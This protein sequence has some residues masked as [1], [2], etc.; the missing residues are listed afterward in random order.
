MSQQ[1]TR[2]PSE[3]REKQGIAPGPHLARVVGHLDPSYMGTLKVRILRNRGNTPGEDSKTYNVKPAFPFFGYTGYEYM[4]VNDAG[5]STLDAYNDTQKSYGMWFVPPDIGV[6]VLIM[7]V[8]GDPAQGFWVGCVPSNFA[9]HMVPAIGA[10]PQVDMDSRDKERFDTNKPLPVAEINRRRNTIAEPQPQI[11]PAQIK[12]PLHPIAE[13]FLEQGLVEDEIRGSTTTT[14][15]RN[16]PSSVYGIS[17][18]GPRDKRP[19]AKKGIIGSADSPA[20]SFISRLGGTQFVMD[21]G[22]ER[23][24]RKAPAGELPFE[25]AYADL[26]AGEKGD[27]AI[28]FNEYFRVRTRTG[29]QILMHNSEDL[30]YIG[31]SRGT[32]WIELTSNGKIDI[33]AQDS[34]SIHTENDLNVRA[35][36]DINMEA[37]RNVNIKAT[38]EYQDKENLHEEKSPFDASGHESGRVYIESVQNMDL[39]IGRNGKIHVKN[40]DQVEGNLDI[41]VMGNMRVSVKDLNEDPPSFTSVSPTRNEATQGSPDEDSQGLHIYSHKNTKIY[42]KENF[43]SITEGNCKVKIEGTSDIIANGDAKLFVDSNLDITISKDAKISSGGSLHINTTSSNNFTA[44]GDTNI[45]SGGQHIEEAAK[46]NMNGPP[47]K[48]ADL[49]SLAKEAGKADIADLVR[50]LPTYD[51]IKI[52]NY[53]DWT[54]IRHRDGAVNS[55]MKRI[56]MHEPWPNHE[57]LKP[58]TSTPDD[59]DREKDD[60]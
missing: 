16:L 34:I 36:R 19:G 12:K 20:T 11:D 51:N 60:G 56:P 6:V 18:P 2:T 15:R 47:A 50:L 43:D 17:T 32:T 22:D 59:T 31:N 30:I 49:A 40:A 33:Y 8:N 13:K 46:I 45:L 21:D 57:N 27:P 58:D 42:T 3:R 23:F 55:I 37:G 9:N 39:L 29:H 53:V 4:G 7:F 10:A 48:A 28:P 54:A 26:L 52:N 5:S 24:Q 35:D 14:S 25:E 38:A 41:K 44:G 1:I